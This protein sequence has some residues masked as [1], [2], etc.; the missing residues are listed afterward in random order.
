MSGPQFVELVHGGR[1]LTVRVEQSLPFSHNGQNRYWQPH[2]T[3]GDERRLM[4]REEHVE[5]AEQV[6][7]SRLTLCLAVGLIAVILGTVGFGVAL[8]LRMDAVVA[9]TT[10]AVAPHAATI[11]HQFIGIVNDTHKITANLAGTTGTADSLI[12]QAQPLLKRALNTSSALLSRLDSFSLHP[13]IS[14][15]GG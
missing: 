2:H 15:S 13:S 9:E 8:Y 3:G 11:L 4:Q 5:G 7:L 6:G 14:I 12:D 1:P 10:A